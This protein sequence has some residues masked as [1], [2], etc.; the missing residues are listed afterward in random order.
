MEFVEHL[1][2]SIDIVKIVEEYVRL[3]KNGSRWIG[4]CPFHNEKTPSFGVNAT[5]QF[6]KCFGCG[7]GGDVLKFVMEIEG[8]TFFEALK[9]LAERNGIPMPK[10]QEYSDPESRRRTALLEM[11]EIAGEVFRANLFGSAG[12]AARA[13]L[14]KRG[15]GQDMV[16]EFGLGLSDRSGTG[17]LRILEQKAFTPEQVEDSGLASRRQDGSGFFDRF[18]GRLMFPIQNESGK[19]IAFGG[20]ALAA[21][22]EPKYLNSPETTLYH[23]SQVLYNLHRAKSA[24]RKMDRVVLVEGYMDVIGV[25]AAGIHEV[26]AS[27]GTSLTNA[28]VRAL[29]RHSERIVVNFDPDAAG[30]N[31][32]ERSIQMLLEEGMHVR[33]LQLDGGLDP[34]EYVK[35]RGADA[36]RARLDKA[37]AYFHWL[38]DQARGKFD[39]RSGEGRFEAFEYLLPAIQKIPDKLER[40]AVANDLAGYLGVEPGMVLEQFRKAA[41]D[42]R[43]RVETSRNVSSAAI[44]PAEHLLLKALLNSPEARAS[45]LERLRALTVVRQFR[46]AGIFRALFTAA[47]QD[48]GV[49]FAKLESRLDESDR[50][51]LAQMIMSDEYG[52]AD[53]PQQAAHCLAALEVTETA[54]HVTD[55][56]A[57]LKAAERSGN[58]E[59]ALRLASELDGLRATKR[60]RTGR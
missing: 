17:L 39:M 59:E 33:I 22:D 36:Y 37:G 41:G 18:R 52:D 40:A 19:I 4:L 24:V 34:D 28:Q 45:T 31:A 14:A 47:E 1:K 5:H 50:A 46:S 9:L 13:Y 15:V 6:Y 35:D 44:P 56:E 49:T 16:A 21:D 53:W 32:A 20:R 58:L 29:K 38:A 12:A 23:K 26:V 30:A 60:N 8:V 55:L 2:S 7:A 3:R 11:H 10:R 25:Y 54:M 51:L 27:C 57:R 48:A 42:R 43:N